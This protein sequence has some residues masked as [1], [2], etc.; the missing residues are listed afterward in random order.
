MI[1][2][3]SERRFDH[4]SKDSYT[5][6]VRVRGTNGGRDDES[7][8][9]TIDDLDEKPT[10]NA[11]LI[12][13]SGNNL[14]NPFDFTVPE[15]VEPDREPL[16]YAAVVSGMDSLPAGVEFDPDTREFTVT[17]DAPSG[18]YVIVVTATD[19][20]STGSGRSNEAAMV[21]SADFTLS[22]TNVGIFVSALRVPPFGRELRSTQLEF[23]ISDAPAINS[24]VTVTV[25]VTNFRGNRDL[26][27][28]SPK[29]FVF[30]AFNFS[31]PRTVG[32][33][34]SDA[35]MKSKG[36]LNAKVRFQV[37]R[38]SES[39]ANY[40]SVPIVLVDVPIDIPN[41]DPVF[42]ESQ[43][44]KEVAE[45]IGSV[46]STIWEPVGTPVAATDEDNDDETEIIYRINPPHPLFAILPFTGQLIH[47]NETN[48]DYESGPTSYTVTIEAVDNEVLKGHATVTVVLDIT[49]V[50]EPPELAALAPQVV[51]E[52]GRRNLPD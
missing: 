39:A 1:I 50:N 21:G 10:W 20:D 22:I 5:I 29:S 25:F 19:P 3:K 38:P 4:E 27:T 46:L 41:K 12:N 49:D 35:G 9:L 23:N 32:I 30:D 11:D 15:A 8:I 17:K 13:R 44:R 37:W 16:T 18:T 33:A 47:K 48:F 24:R 2:L 6:H 45:H 7:L 14:L 52:G 26:L 51:I 28:V 31:T 42:N 43:R 36:Q 40:R 34:L